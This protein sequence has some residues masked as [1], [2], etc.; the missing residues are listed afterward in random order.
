MDL[1]KVENQILSAGKLLNT[2]FIEAE[3]EAKKA[4]RLASGNPNLFDSYENKVADYY[5][6][7]LGKEITRKK[8]SGEKVDHPKEIQ[9]M[10]AYMKNGKDIVNALANGLM[11]LSPEFRQQREQ[12]IKEYLEK[13][14]NAQ[15]TPRDGQIQYRVVRPYGE[16]GIPETAFK[17]GLAP[18]FVSVWHFQQ[19]IISKPYI[20]DASNTIGEK[21]GWTGGISSTSANLKF[22]SA[23]DFAASHG[24]QDGWI[25][26]YAT[27]VAASV[28][29]HIT[30]GTGYDGIV[31]NG[32]ERS[33]A[34]AAMEY[35]V[36]YMAPENIVAARRV[37]R[38]GKLKEIVFNK[39]VTISVFGDAEYLKFLLCESVDELR[40]LEFLEMKSAEIKNNND[41]SLYVKAMVD[42]FVNLRAKRQAEL[43]KIASASNYALRELLNNDF[44]E[45]LYE[46][47]PKKSKKLQ[48]LVMHLG[49]T[50]QIPDV[51]TEYKR[52]ELEAEIDKTPPV[53]LASHFGYEF[54]KEKKVNINDP[55]TR[56]NKLQSRYEQYKNH[57]PKVVAVKIDSLNDLSK[58]KPKK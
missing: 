50:E 51:L 6:S 26:A 30:F 43:I 42:L 21:V 15:Y 41:G 3:R 40:L 20:N 14:Y 12:Y 55:I 58:K 9:D 1:L 8:K 31:R 57:Q 54:E 10:E 49:V 29:H 4:I 33:N 18:Q 23:F 46:A 11:I 35:M 13:E 7:I 44:Q 22:T 45:G 24:Q 47:Q 2:N 38:D 52:Q 5:N 28:A 16:Y 34:E 17:E 53:L 32:T 27:D 56:P 36:N 39:R 19:G 48:K 37:S 25:Y